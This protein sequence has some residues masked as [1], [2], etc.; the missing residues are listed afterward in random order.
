MGKILIILGFWVLAAI[1]VVVMRKVSPESNIIY[2]IHAIFV[3]IF[4][5]VCTWLFY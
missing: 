5:S 4:F 2:P 1:C 3:G